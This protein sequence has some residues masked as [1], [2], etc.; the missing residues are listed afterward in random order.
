[1]TRPGP[2][3]YAESPS[4]DWPARLERARGAETLLIRLGWLVIVVS[5]L[6]FA[7][8]VVAIAVGYDEF[9]HGIVVLSGIVLGGVLAGAAAFGSG[10]NIGINAERLQRDLVRDMREGAPDSPH[11]SGETP[12]NGHAEA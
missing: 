1:M 4:R 5:T 6:A 2:A 11:P 3:E 12:A 9:A 7:S 8:E 10:V